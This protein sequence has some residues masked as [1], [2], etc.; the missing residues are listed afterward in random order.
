MYNDYKKV[1]V[2]DDNLNDLLYIKKMLEQNYNVTTINEPLQAIEI[3]KKT[4][5][6]YI[7]LDVEMPELNGFE[8]LKRINKLRNP[9]IT[10]VIIISGYSLVEQLDNYAKLHADSYILKPFIQEELLDKLKQL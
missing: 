10:K 7:L 8:T 9:A 4:N 3:I 6:D 1:L 5:Y 2:I